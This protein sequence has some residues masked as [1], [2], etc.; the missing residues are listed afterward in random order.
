[1][2]D[3][4]AALVIERVRATSFRTD[5]GTDYLIQVRARTGDGRR[6]DAM[7]LARP[8]GAATGDRGEVS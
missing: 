6:V 5:D 1:M 8:R 7:G 4:S 3:P 2:A